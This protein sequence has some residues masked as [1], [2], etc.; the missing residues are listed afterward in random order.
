VV[1]R[2]ETAPHE[3][4]A[5]AAAVRPSRWSLAVRE[6]RHWM[7]N[8]R[9][10]WRGTIYSSVLNPLLYLSAIGIVLGTLVNKHGSA[11]LGG[12]SYIAFLAPGL[13]AAAAMET[14][15]GES[16]YP[17]FGSVKWRRTYY[18]AAATPLRPSDLLHGHLLFTTLRLAMNC[19]IFIAVMTAFGAVKSVW[20]L[21][22]LPV[23]VLTGLAFAIPIEAWAIT[24]L[25]D[26]SFALLFRFGLI[27]LFLF[28]GTFFPVSQL[29]GWAQPIAYATP[30]WH[31]VVLCRSLSLGTATPGEALLHVGYL[32]VLAGA[33]LAAGHR[34]YRRRLYV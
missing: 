12:I 9:R 32:A 8:Y 27:P 25:K 18:A 33:G 19:A 10:T 26:T 30:L 2:A 11:K 15:I 14:G 3:P 23:A 16:T 34:T 24:V 1:S 21:A 4:A 13:L 6:F 29:P 7:T 31:G 22:A 17:V 5:A 20:V 28:S